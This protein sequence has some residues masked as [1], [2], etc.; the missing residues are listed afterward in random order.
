MVKASRSTS[1]RGDEGRP[2]LGREVGDGPG[3]LGLGDP[4]G[5][6]QGGVAAGGDRQLHLSAVVGAGPALHE[7]LSTSQSTSRLMAGSDRPMKSA[8]ADSEQPE[9]VLT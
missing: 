1:H 9:E 7:P 2:L 4:P 3:E 8:A 6:P 5:L